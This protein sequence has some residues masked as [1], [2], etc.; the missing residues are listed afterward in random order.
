MLAWLNHLGSLL[1]RPLHTDDPVFPAISARGDLKFG[2]KISRPGIDA[3]LAEV[4]DASQVLKGR[5]GKFT[6]HCFRRG[7]AQ[8]MFMWAENKWSLKVVK[9]WGGWSSNEDVS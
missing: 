9:W 4:V 5:I 6:L 8:F 1:Q 2:E 3:L 7:G